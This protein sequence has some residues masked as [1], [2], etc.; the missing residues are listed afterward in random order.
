ME[1]Y[2]KIKQLSFYKQ[3][4]KSKSLENR[5]LRF[6]EHT[7]LTVKSFVEYIVCW[8]SSK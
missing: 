5:G 6:C 2:R 1:N 7:F 3:S 8:F 4:L